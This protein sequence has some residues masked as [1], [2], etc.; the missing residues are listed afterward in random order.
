MRQ[1]LFLLLL[2]SFPLIGNC[3]F[4]DY[5]IV[6][7]NDSIIYDSRIDRELYERVYGINLSKIEVKETETFVIEYVTD[8][9]CPSCEYSLSFH[10]KSGLVIR[11]FTSIGP[12]PFIFTKEEIHDIVKGELEVV[13]RNKDLDFRRT[14]LKIGL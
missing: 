8:T 6:R 12:S 7:I 3:D 4:A 10:T 13:Y 11:E 1:S 9:P 2:L 5:I 14:I